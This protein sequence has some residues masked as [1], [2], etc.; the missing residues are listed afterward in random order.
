ARDGT[1]QTLGPRMLQ[2]HLLIQLADDEALI[3][4]AQEDAI[5]ARP[6]SDMLHRKQMLAELKELASG[7]GDKYVRPRLA[8][9][10]SALGLDGELRELAATSRAAAKHYAWTLIR[11]GDWDTVGP[12]VVAGDTYLQDALRS[13]LRNTPELD[14]TAQAIKRFGFNPDGT[15]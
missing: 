12:L 6:A 8:S 2:S 5:A 7:S 1:I 15:V 11:R 10:L 14:D 13:H 9:L 3:Q 4:L